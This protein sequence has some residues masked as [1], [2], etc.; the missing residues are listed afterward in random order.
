MEKHSNYPVSRVSVRKTPVQ[1]AAD[2]GP[3]LTIVDGVVTGEKEALQ[4]E[5]KKGDRYYAPP[6][7]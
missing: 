1:L 7:M 3:W 6:H 5:K 4:L 2:G